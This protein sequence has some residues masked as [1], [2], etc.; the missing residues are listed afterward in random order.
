MRAS[1]FQVHDICLLFTYLFLYECECVN[2]AAFCV[3]LAHSQCPIMHISDA[4][5]NSCIVHIPTS[6]S[7]YVEWIVYN[8]ESFI[9]QL[10]CLKRILRCH[11]LNHVKTCM[12]YAYVF[13]K[14]DIFSGHQ[15]MCRHSPTLFYTPQMHRTH[16]ENQL[17]FCVSVFGIH[18]H[19]AHF[20]IFSTMLRAAAASLC[21]NVVRG[22]YNTSIFSLPCIV[23]STYFSHT[24]HLFQV[25]IIIVVTM[26]IF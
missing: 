4:S 25:E 8:R 18:F 22:E 9:C 16:I 3:W 24:K 11:T 10:A 19:F 20:G 5:W 12:L 15:M 6:T 13:R 21:L 1:A 23:G 17:S 7:T 2:I 14:S 26:D